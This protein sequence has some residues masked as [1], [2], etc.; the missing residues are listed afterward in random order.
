[1]DILHTQWTQVLEH[2]P[3]RI[4]YT[5]TLTRITLKGK[6]QRL[7]RTGSAIFAKDGRF[8]IIEKE[9]VAGGSAESFAWDGKSLSRSIEPNNTY[10]ISKEHFGT[11]IDP[12]ADAGFKN[13]IPIID[14][15]EGLTANGGGPPFV[16][17]NGSE[18]PIPALRMFD[19]LAL[20]DRYYSPTP[21]KFG[22]RWCDSEDNQLF[23]KGV[24]RA[25]S[26]TNAGE[27]R[28][29]AFTSRHQHPA[30]G[31]SYFMQ[32]A[33][34]PRTKG[35][36]DY[37]AVTVTNRGT[38]DSIIEQTSPT[39]KPEDLEHYCNNIGTVT[40]FSYSDK[41]ADGWFPEA[42]TNDD[43][44]PKNEETVRDITPAIVASTSTEIS[45]GALVFFHE[46]VGYPV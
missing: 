19:Y 32:I 16:T 1:M 37:R 21:G 13:R 39:V 44:E 38:W 9:G 11:Y 17:L 3:F 42:V 26:I 41:V 14:L 29:L 30:R 25:D 12:I 4:E 43:Y 45:N 5:S 24:E 18:I 27:T 28:I 20:Q 31:T 10:F 8:I 34:T 35:A 7:P 6:E 15:L 23:T 36:L 33:L 2:A 46:V 22:P 40:R